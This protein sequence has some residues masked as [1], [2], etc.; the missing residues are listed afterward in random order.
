MPINPKR[1]QAE[2]KELTDNPLDYADAFPD[3]D[4]IHKWYFMLIGVEGPFLGG[5]YLGV[6]ELPKDY[7][8]SAP[9]MSFLTPSG[10][11][12][13]NMNICL[14]NSHFH[15]ESHSPAWKIHRYIMALISV[16]DDKTVQHG[17]AHLTKTKA[18]REKYRDQSRSYNLKHHAKIY[19]NPRFAR[20]INNADKMMPATKGGLLSHFG[21]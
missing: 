11:F 7:P 9:K 19:T 1:I 6:I 8:H 2:I 12:D 20:L 14:S 15:P 17:V 10:R 3:E 5:I 4:D 21:M 16:F 13:I 18:E